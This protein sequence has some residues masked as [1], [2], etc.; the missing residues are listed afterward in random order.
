MDLRRAP[1]EAAEIQQTVQHPLH[2]GGGLPQIVEPLLDEGGIV[3][4][5]RAHFAG[6]A[7]L[8]HRR[9]KFMR[10]IAGEP[11]FAVCGCLERLHERIDRNG[12]RGDL[13]RRV[14]QVDAS[15]Q[16]VGAQ[17]G[18]LGVKILKRTQA[19]AQRDADQ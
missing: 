18:N 1:V 7:E 15:I 3:G 6:R 10:D 14:G 19:L 5:F 8:R 2:V 4:P 17:P 9:S 13:G 11:P 16:C 12:E